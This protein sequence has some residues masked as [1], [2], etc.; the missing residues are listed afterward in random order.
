M[1]F[2]LCLIQTEIT[3]SQHIVQTYVVTQIQKCLWYM[4]NIFK[5][6][7][8]K[9]LGLL[10]NVNHILKNIEMIHKYNKDIKI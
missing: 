8:L 5:N 4:E 10:F 7:D 3:L 1:G 6:K 9:E 2:F